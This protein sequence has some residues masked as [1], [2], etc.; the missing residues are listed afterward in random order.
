MK[1]IIVLL[2]VLLLLVS[3]VQV[4]FANPDPD[5]EQTPTT[6]GACHMGAS[7]WEPGAGPG[8]AYGVESGERGM[9]HVHTKDSPVGYTNG[10]TNMDLIA[11]A[12]CD[13]GQ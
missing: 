5:P 3:T 2:V 1:K 4:A 9:N 7:V 6:I 10:A 12:H 8:N 13:F 11:A